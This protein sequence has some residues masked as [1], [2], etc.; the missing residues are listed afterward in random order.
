MT[1]RMIV[2]H[3]KLGRGLIRQDWSRRVQ[4]AR[5]MLVV[6]VK[7]VHL[8]EAQRR[9]QTVHQENFP[10]LHVAQALVH[11]KTAHPGPIAPRVPFKHRHACVLLG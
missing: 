10:H 6:L 7:L 8:L 2:L 9:A 3:V 4:T 5:A 1:T 11:A